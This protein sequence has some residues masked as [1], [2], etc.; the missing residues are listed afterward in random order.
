MTSVSCK[1]LA[2]GVTS[3]HNGTSPKDASGEKGLSNTYRGRCVNAGAFSFKI[4]QS[5]LL[6]E[7]ARQTLPDYY[8]SVVCKM[9]V[10]AEIY[11]TISHLRHRKPFLDFGGIIYGIGPQ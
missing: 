7:L 10:L 8:I 1:M 2:Y 3:L 11:G 4:K 5:Q 6:R 9:R